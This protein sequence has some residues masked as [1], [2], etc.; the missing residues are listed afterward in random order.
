MARAVAD[1]AAHRD[2]GRRLMLRRLGSDMTTI[3]EHRVRLWQG[4]IETQIE[5]IGDGPPLVFLHGPWGLRD[6]DFLDHLAVTHRIFAPKHP[7]ISAGDPDAIHQ[8]DESW[9]LVVYYGELFDWLRLEA[10]VLWPFFWW[11]DCLR[12]RRD[13]AGT[14]EQ[15]RPDRSARA[16]AG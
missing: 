4:K 16:L 3:E 13:N 9:D 11:H 15:A 8:L 14:S 2:R 10:P 1:Q 7:G 6:R 12:D 5:V